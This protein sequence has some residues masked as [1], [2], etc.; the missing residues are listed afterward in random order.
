MGDYAV[1][2]FINGEEIIAKVVT[3]SKDEVTLSD[4]VQIHRIVSPVGHEL[5]RCSYWML[6]NDGPEVTVNRNHVITFVQDVSKN[7]VR[8]YEM[9]LERAEHGHVDQSLGEVVDDTE[10]EMKEV[11]QN[12]RNADARARSAAFRLLEEQ[13]VFEEDMDLEEEINPVHLIRPTANTIH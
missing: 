9:F 3:A 2:K 5:I 4:P 12:L 7:T 8:H 11:E 6:F 13:G 1:V 10:Q